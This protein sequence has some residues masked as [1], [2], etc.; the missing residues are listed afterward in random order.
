MLASLA[1]VWP[2][3]AIGLMTLLFVVVSVILVLTVLIQKPQG[4]GLSGAFGSGA[5]SGQ[6]AFG[7]KTGDALTVATIIIFAVYLLLGVVLVFAYR[8]HAAGVV[9]P[10]SGTPTAPAGGSTA[11]A[12][13]EKS[14]EAK[15]AD[16]KPAGNAPAEG[17]AKPAGEKPADQTAPSGQAPATTPAATPGTTPPATTTP[18]SPAPLPATP[19]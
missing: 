13:S 17:A 19:K 2:A 3:W 16:A 18:V 14:G 10:A 5:G 1:F 12:T 9:T 7:T 11:P 4:G 15:P 6:T 8:P